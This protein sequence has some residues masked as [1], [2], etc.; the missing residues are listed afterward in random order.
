[1]RY[2]HRNHLSTA[3]LAL[4]AGSMIS[5]SA[6]AGDTEALARLQAAQEAF[7]VARAELIAA[8]AEAARFTDVQVAETSVPAASD[9]RAQPE[10]EAPPPDPESWKD[11]WD[12]AATMGFSG[13]SG[14]NENFAAR[15]SVLGERNTSK[16][17]TKAGVS[18]IYGTSEGT[19]STSRGEVFVHNDWLTDSK[20]R[21]FAEGKWEYDEFQAWDHRL[22][23]AVGVG[24]EII[25]NDKHTLIGR[26][27]LGGSYEIGDTANE[28]FIPEGLL[29]LDWTYRISESTTLKAAS[30][31]YPSFDDLGEFRWNNTA[32]LEV[33]MD[34]DTGMTLN[35][36]F[37]HRHQSNPGSGFKSN[38][39]DYYMGIGWKF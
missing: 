24:Y 35:T 30:T 11:G 14:N 13:A 28:E 2:T 27:G 8:Q 5:S 22:S 26:A 12:L 38:D 15:A 36:G 25:D 19:A 1:M 29:G 7:E 9:V 17:E 16:Y 23:G 37:E 4:A 32:G 31:Y 39:L 34:A 10:E 33:V 21:Y 20:W 3:I 18:Y 6:L